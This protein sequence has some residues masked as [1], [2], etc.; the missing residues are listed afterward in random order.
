M[1]ADICVHDYC[2]ARL[3]TV[4][5]ESPWGHFAKALDVSESTVRRTPA[6]MGTSTFHHVSLVAQSGLETVQ[7]W[8]SSLVAPIRKELCQSR[9]VLAYLFEIVRVNHFPTQ[10]R[11]IG[12]HHFAD[13]GILAFCKSLIDYVRKARTICMT[14]PLTG[15]AVVQTAVFDLSDWKRIAPEVSEICSILGAKSVVIAR[16]R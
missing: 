10:M 13:S 12:K 3:S 5:Q 15:I 8:I 1:I 2:A 7:L 16:R 6:S 14:S 4:G 9:A 11:R